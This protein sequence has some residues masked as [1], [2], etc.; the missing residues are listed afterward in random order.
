MEGGKEV[1]NEN[2]DLQKIKRAFKPSLSLPIYT[3]IIAIAPLLHLLLDIADRNY[4]RILM[5]TLLS[6]FLTV[7]I[8]FIWTSYYYKMINYKR[9]IKDYKENPNAYKW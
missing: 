9:E 3:T 2:E 6:T 1:G 4:E 7:Y 5:L 8:T